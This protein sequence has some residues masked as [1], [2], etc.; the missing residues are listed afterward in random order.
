MRGVV[1]RER[2]ARA[3]SGL[4]SAEFAKFKSSSNRSRD[5]ALLTNGP[6]R[7][8]PTQHGAAVKDSRTRLE[9]L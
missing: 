7:S 9:T 8:R 2:V 1:E 6:P 3:R 5:A 4:H